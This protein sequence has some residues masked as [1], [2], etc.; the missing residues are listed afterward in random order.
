MP[1][2]EFYSLV[3][4]GSDSGRPQTAEIYDTTTESWILT[5]DQVLA[6]GDVD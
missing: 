4:G 1:L 3:T 5:S 6:T 2:Y